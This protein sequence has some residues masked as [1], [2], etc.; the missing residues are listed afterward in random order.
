MSASPP[1][2]GSSDAG[3]LCRKGVVGMRRREKMIGVVLDA[4]STTVGRERVLT[5]EPVVVACAVR[6]QWDGRP[7]DTSH[8]QRRSP[9]ARVRA[10]QTRKPFIVIKVRP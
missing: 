1:A 5:A 8:R 7:T 10:W 4:L 6:C 9:S 3:P 2:E